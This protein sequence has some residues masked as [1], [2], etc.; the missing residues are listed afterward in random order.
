LQGKSEPTKEQGVKVKLRDQEAS[1]QPAEQ[2]TRGVRFRLALTGEGAHKNVRVLAPGRRL[3][4]QDVVTF[5]ES[6]YTELGFSQVIPSCMCRSWKGPLKV[7]FNEAYDED[8]DTN[9][10]MVIVWE[11][12]QDS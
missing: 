3:L 12:S 6:E 5:R 8:T 4:R 1:Q 7:R 11:E 9:E 10:N 2:W